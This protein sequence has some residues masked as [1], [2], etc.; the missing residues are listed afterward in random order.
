MLNST[1]I[2]IGYAGRDPR[3]GTSDESFLQV[4]FS[5]QKMIKVLLLFFKKKEKYVI[6]KLRRNW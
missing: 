6:V 4:L 5:S 1:A 2:P 3:G